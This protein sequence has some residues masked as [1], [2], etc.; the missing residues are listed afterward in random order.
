MDNERAIRD[1]AVCYLDLLGF[2]KLTE[3]HIEA[4][5]DLLGNYN[6]LVRDIFLGEG[7]LAD[8][9]SS[10]T[11]DYMSPT[12]YFLPM[13]DSLFI[14]SKS[15]SALVANV[16]SFLSSTFIFTGRVFADGA[17]KSDPREVTL[18]EISPDGISHS[19]QLWHPSLFRGGL[20]Y[21]DIRRLSQTAIIDAAPVGN[22]PNLA[23]SSITRAVDA[24]R[25]RRH[26]KGPRL[27]CDPGFCDKLTDSCRELY[28]EVD[29]ELGEEVL[30]PIEAIS[31]TSKRVDQIRLV[32][33]LRSALGLLSAF[34]DQQYG[35]HYIEFLKLVA[36]SA[37]RVEKLNP[38]GLDIKNA[39]RRLQ[40]IYE[41]DAL[42]ILSEVDF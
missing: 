25:T 35:S 26:I 28:I 20:S 6:A 27:F 24:E 32:D 38:Q 16:S 8:E 4:G 30:W 19:V 41:V 33:L 42:S 12:Q 9:G 13:S 10:P 21:G 1:S 34:W 23:G 22:H 2:S 3:R 18:I 31:D 39:I 17:G 5:V 7:D 36:K 29:R 14:T 40:D 15:A 37:C 11:L